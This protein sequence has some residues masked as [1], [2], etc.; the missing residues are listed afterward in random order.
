LFA[1]VWE[2]LQQK[3]SPSFSDTTV[4]QATATA[5]NRSEHAHTSS[6]TPATSSSR[7]SGENSTTASPVELF[8][9]QMMKQE[10]RKQ[11]LTP[12]ILSGL[13]S[14][15]TAPT[16]SSVASAYSPLDVSTTTTT[17]TTTTELIQ[18]TQQIRRA[19]VSRIRM[20]Q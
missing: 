8:E 4:T 5:T 16:T 11:A 17:T 2:Y 20:R 1:A 6:A 18:Y 10:H 14:K 7:V 3:T 15:M 13:L 9:N 12:V 19:A